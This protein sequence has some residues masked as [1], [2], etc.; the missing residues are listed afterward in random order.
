MVVRVRTVSNQRLLPL[1]VDW[2][3]AAPASSPRVQPDTISDRVNEQ[4]L[5]AT[6]HLRPDLRMSDERPTEVPPSGSKSMSSRMARERVRESWTQLLL[7]AN[8]HF[9]RRWSST[10]R[11]FDI[12]LLD[13]DC[14]VGNAWILPSVS[15][16]RQSDN[17]HSLLCMS[18][19]RLWILL[20]AQQSDC[21]CRILLYLSHR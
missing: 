21:A 8:F 7:G 3:K 13:I 6:R 2:P 19:R 17:G 5:F 14:T 20:S 18:V 9:L 16:F 1:T 15:T 4:R 12:W 11:Q 10:I